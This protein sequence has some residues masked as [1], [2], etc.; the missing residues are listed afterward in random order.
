ME[1]NMLDET[2]AKEFVRFLK[3]ERIYNM[4]QVETISWC[5]DVTIKNQNSYFNAQ[6]S[7][8]IMSMLKLRLHYGQNP[9][10]VLFEW[11]KSKRGMTFWSS[12]NKIYKGRYQTHTI[13]YIL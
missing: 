11:N 3:D 1:A 12:K 4:F 13:P 7:D 6:L 2:N 8:G 9:L 5:Y 10:V